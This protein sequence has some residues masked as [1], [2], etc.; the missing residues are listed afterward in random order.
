[1]ALECWRKF[2]IEPFKDRLVKLILVEIYNDR[3]GKSVNQKVLHGVINS[4]VDVA[5]KRRKPLEVKLII[6]FSC[7]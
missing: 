7:L 3:I 2:M 4:L 5:D 1:M 6:L